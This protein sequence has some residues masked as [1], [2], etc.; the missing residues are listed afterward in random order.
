M[1]QRGTTSPS[2]VYAL[3]LD[4]GQEEFHVHR[5]LTLAGSLSLAMVSDRADLQW[6]LLAEMRAVTHTSTSF[7]P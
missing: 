7:D 2:A 5:S 6:L 1:V 3:F 4:I